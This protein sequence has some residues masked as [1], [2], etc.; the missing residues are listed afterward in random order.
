LAFGEGDVIA[1][2]PLDQVL[3]DALAPK[4]AASLFLDD[5]DDDDDGGGFGAESVSS[6]I[7]SYEATHF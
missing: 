7:M 6:Q 4:V 1:R 2:F 3:S 5:D